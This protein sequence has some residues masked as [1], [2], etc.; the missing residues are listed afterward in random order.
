MTETVSEQAEAPSITMQDLQ[1]LLLIV[2]AAAERG[3]FKGNELSSVGAT[4]DKL[5]NFLS[6]A[7]KVEEA[8]AEPQTEESPDVAAA[9]DSNAA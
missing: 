9:E 7:T 4:R 1:N 8:A 6:A 2:D 3:A 5:A